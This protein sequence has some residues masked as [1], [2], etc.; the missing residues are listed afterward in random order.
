MA[1]SDVSQTGRWFIPASAGNTIRYQLIAR[2]TPVHPR[3][4]GEHP[5]VSP[6][7]LLRGGSSPRARGTPDLLDDL[8]NQRRFIPASA[9]NTCSLACPICSR[10]VHPRERGEHNSMASAKR[11]HSGSSPRARGTRGLRVRRELQF[12]FIPASA[13]NTAPPSMRHWAI[14]VHPRERGEHLRVHFHH[15]RAGGSS[16]RARG[17]QH[18]RA[19]GRG[20]CRFIPASAGNTLTRWLGRGTMAVHPRERGEH[21]GARH[22]GHRVQ[23]FI[24]ASAGNT[25]RSRRLSSSRPVHPRERGEHPR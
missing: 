20:P 25:S 18:A 2:G 5:T 15:V 6:Q 7:S 4:R 9:G 11:C 1:V 19:P 13:G 17:T 21:P 10:S 16:P 12:R 3:E 22:R 24:P 14:A 8:L 23:R